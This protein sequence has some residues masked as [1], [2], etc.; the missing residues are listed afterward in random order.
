MKKP[1]EEIYEKE[2]NLE[3]NFRVTLEPNEAASLIPDWWTKKTLDTFRK[4]SQKLESIIKEMMFQVC[5]NCTSNSK[6]K[7]IKC[8]VLFLVALAQEIELNAEMA[9]NK[10][11]EEFYAAEKD[12][13]HS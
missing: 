2:V 5:L 7:C 11:L 4:A 10:Q 3:I 6:E 12:K 1:L 8:I 9:I 13:G